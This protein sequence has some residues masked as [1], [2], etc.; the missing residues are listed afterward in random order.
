M[1]AHTYTRRH[2]PTHAHTPTLTT[3]PLQGQDKVIFIFFF[4][5]ELSDAKLS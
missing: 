2:V 4:P 1:H 5:M 3:F